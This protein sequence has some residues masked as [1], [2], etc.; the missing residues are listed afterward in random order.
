MKY[1]AEIISVG[2]SRD[3]ELRSEPELRSI[4]NMPLL[5]FEGMIALINKTENPFSPTL[6]D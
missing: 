5:I 3:V 4:N 1:E 6:P 2:D